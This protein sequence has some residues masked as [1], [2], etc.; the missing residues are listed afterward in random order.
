MSVSRPTRVAAETFRGDIQ[1]GDVVDDEFI[2]SARH[3]D[4]LILVDFGAFR[5]W[6]SVD[7]VESR[8]PHE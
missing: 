4:H 1:T 7:E 3:T 6:F 5:E 8:T 2:A